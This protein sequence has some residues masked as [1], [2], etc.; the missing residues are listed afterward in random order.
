MLK[1]K[2]S[3]VAN[4]FF[5]FD[6]ET[7]G[8]RAK[9]DAFVF[10]V[11][12][13]EKFLKVIHSVD[14][15]KKEFKKPMY[16]NK[17]IFAHNAEY[18]LN[19]IYDNIYDMDIKPIFNNRF[20]S[21]T[22]GNCFFADSFNILPT[23]VKKIGELLGLS[24]FEIESNFEKGTVTKVSKKMIKYCIRDCEIIYEG[25]RDIFELIGSVRITLASLAMDFYRR[26]FQPF[27]IDF[28]EVLCDKFYNSYFGGRTEVFKLGETHSYAID[29]NSMYPFAM[30]ECEF[31]NPKLLRSKKFIAPDMF[32]S[33]YLNYF[34]GT[35]HIK[36]RH[37]ESFFGT[38]P[39]KNDGKLI[40]PV[41]IFSG[42]WNFNEIRFAYE[43][44]FIEI[45]EVKE[46]IFA[47]KIKG[48]L[49]K[50]VDFNYE[51]R[52]KTGNEFEKY[53]FKLL[54][55][56][57]YGKFAQ[58]ILTEFIYIKD[59]EKQYKLIEKYEKK[60]LL[61]KIKPFSCERKDVFIE[62][63]SPKN[64]K[65]YNSIP[66]IA[67]YITSYSRVYLLKYLLKYTEYLPVYCDTDSIFLEKLPNIIES[68][69]LGGWK[70]EN[71]IIK[72]IRGLKNYSYLVDE[73]IIDKIKGV[74]KKAEKTGKNV[75]KY[76][77][78][79]KTKEAL[80]RNTAPGVLI[81]RE[82]ILNNTYNKRIIL[83]DGW[84]KPIKLC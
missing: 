31:P 10:G 53:L 59:I 51:K 11:V 66:L 30:R 5:V 34:E 70:I 83:N 80:R 65:I 33:K 82:K 46:I 54:L 14:D 47:E 27:H 18:D 39:L 81:N 84:T 67:S 4:D 68:N 42:W 29:I 36:V 49:K 23:S 38:L 74:P 22:N 32:T 57:L 20:I 24:K 71:K 37:K 19:V 6:T 48:I 55:N 61:I 76:K 15:F 16:R 13:G 28:N 26:K 56:S 21:A 79:L 78:L 3:F 72:N 52:Q 40:F 75:Y 8:L 12:Y 60:G 7:N 64:E 41:G 2:S 17:K 44:G 50:Y 69:D 58:R 43:N 35:A 77:S 73:K 1:E 63:K 9:S 25:L 45:L 62:V